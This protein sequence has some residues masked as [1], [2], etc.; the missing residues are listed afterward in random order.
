MRYVAA[1]G[2]L[3]GLANAMLKQAQMPLTKFAITTARW[4]RDAPRQAPWRGKVFAQLVSLLKTDGIPLALRAQSVAAFYWSGDPGAAPLFRQFL[5]TTSFELL[6]LAAL[7][8]GAV[9]DTKAVEQLSGILFAPSPS[10]QR[11]SCLAL[12]AIGSAPAMEIVARS[13]IERGRRLASRRC[14][15][16]CK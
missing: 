12:V 16:S 7:G 13:A 3:T 5:R 14:R 9:C 10:A 6:Q 4:L 1:C 2:M 15:S 8:S 11:A